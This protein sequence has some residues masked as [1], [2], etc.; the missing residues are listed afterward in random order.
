MVKIIIDGRTYEASEDDNLLKACLSAGIDIP[1][2]CYHPALGSVGACR[3]C[4]VKLYKNEDDQQGM[5][6]MSCMQPVQEGMI[7]SVSDPEVV[8]FRAQVIESLMLNHPHDCP[9]CDEGGEC[10]LQD[11]TVMTGH[12][13][14]RNRFPKRTYPNQYLGP[15][16]NHEMN[17]CIQCYRCVRFYKDYAGGGDLDAFGINNHVFFG[18]HQDGP[19]ENEFSGNL[20]EVCPTGVFTDKTL[21][22]HYTRKWDLLTAPSVCTHCGLGCNTIAGERY[23]RLRRIRS[24]YHHQVNGYFL[25]DRGRFGYGFVNSPRRLHHTMSRTKKTGPLEKTQPEKLLK[26][27]RNHLEQDKT[28]AIGSPRA[29][30][31]ANFTLK[32][33]VGAENF[34]SGFAAR[35]HQLMDRVVDILSNRP[36]HIASLKETEKA[37]CVIILGEDVTQYAPMLALSLRQTRMQLAVAK[38]GEQN[39]EPWKDEAVRRAWQDAPAPIYSF[40]PTATKLDK[41]SRRAWRMN[42]RDIARFGFALSHRLNPDVPQPDALPRQ[43]E[44]MIEEIA[45]ALQKAKKPLIVAGTGSGDEAIL[46]AAA[47]LAQ[48]LYNHN[49]EAGIFLT[50]PEANSLGLAL[51]R[52]KS[53][54]DL[55]EPAEGKG[56]PHLIILENDLYRRENK[57]QVSRMLDKW[58]TITV[59]DHLSNETTAKADHIMPSA[60]FT[61]AAGTFI[62]NESRAQRFYKVYT[63]GDAVRESWRWLHDLD[64]EGKRLPGTPWRSLDDCL[65]AI[66]G[67]YDRFKEMVEVAPPSIFR[68]NGR[69]IPRA[70]HRYSGRTSISAHLNV[71]EPKPPD[72]PDSPLSFSMEG[73]RN[74]PPSPLTGFYWS[75]GWNS[76]QAI[77]KYQIEMGGPLHDGDPGRRL[78]HPE[79]NTTMSLY[80]E[81]P[82]VITREKGSYT[83]IPVYHIFGSD[84]LST[85][86]PPIQERIPP[87]CMHIHPSDAQ[88]AGLEAEAMAGLK[89]EDRLIELPVKTD[90]NLAEGTIG[91]PAGFPDVDVHRLPAT[92]WIESK[93]AGKQ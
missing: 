32:T 73:T 51:L 33:L 18:R 53:M 81:T 14:R 65:R 50:V 62:N 13:Y 88:K 44:P 87:P 23:G 26:T 40:N 11:M 74:T 56:A 52:G 20:V 78:L 89:L 12:T 54:E 77:N 21:K 69:K 75:P 41:V 76:P 72:D 8:A 6:I 7:V 82:A 5:L 64:P 55:P 35:E 15:F 37:D 3:Q 79:D 1:Y 17:R 29:S 71:K 86:S 38:A 24:R 42:P 2:F 91:I 27:V 43:W 92:G 9:V 90:E 93:K 10:H 19:L 68:M 36:L 16:I 61:E 83:V 70:P 59:L 66:T 67:Q 80:S 57:E 58:G 47:N 63:P 4:A 34:F 39:I 25:C 28:I 48:L 30:L 22:Q 46:Q 60:A 84:E 31:E 49:P 85:A 45:A